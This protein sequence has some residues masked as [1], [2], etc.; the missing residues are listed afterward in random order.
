MKLVFQEISDRRIVF[1]QPVPVRAE[2]T[3]IIH[4]T[5]IPFDAERFLDMVVEDI[6]IDIG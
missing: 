4:I 2:K 1:F 3:E 6:E 5:Q